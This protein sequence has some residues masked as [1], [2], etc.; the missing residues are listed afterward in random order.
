MPQAALTTPKRGSS[1]TKAAKQAGCSSCALNQASAA[2]RQAASVPPAGIPIASNMT[3]RRRGEAV[4][5]R[6]QDDLKERGGKYT[7]ADRP[8]DTYVVEDGRLIT[9]QNPGSA[10][11]VADAVVKQLS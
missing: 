7:L 6:L 4:P 1:T 3:A 8:F 2:L 11:A 10:K 5:F 9:G